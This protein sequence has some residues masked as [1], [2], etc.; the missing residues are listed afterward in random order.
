M[1]P[2]LELSD[3]TFRYESDAPILEGVSITV[4]RGE[5]VAVT[6]PS[7][8]GK[9]TLLALMGLLLRPDSGRLALHGTAVGDLSDRRRSTLR[10]SEIGF[11]FQ[12]AVL[13]PRRSVL[14]NVVEG[15]FWAGVP[16]ESAR[17]HARSIIRRL[18]V[19]VDPGRRPGQVSGGQA[20]RI[21]LARTI[22][23]RPSIVLAD[24]PTGNLDAGAAG[25]VMDELRELA[26]AGAAVVVA[27]H[28]QQLAR[29]CNRRVEL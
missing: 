1:S 9:S 20:Q 29:A 5:A 8:C 27:T 7:G 14:A 11:V 15:A 25:L 2:A 22:V 28:D 12:D 18:G 23:G 24:E 21:A 10:A 6:G 4:A 26:A 13:D 16:R 3:V 19:D 17:E